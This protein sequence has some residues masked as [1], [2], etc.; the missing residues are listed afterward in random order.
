MSE[1]GAAE[2]AALAPPLCHG[3]P[4]R[5]AGRRRFVVLDSAFGLGHSFL[6]LWDAWRNDPDRCDSLHVVAV[7]APAPTRSDLMQAHAASTLPLLVATLLESWPPLTPNLHVLDFEHGRV[8]LLLAVGPAATSMRMLRLQADAICLDATHGVWT[9]QRLKAVARLA[10]VGATLTVR[11]AGFEELASLPSA[12]FELGPGP[13]DRD[14]TVA[15]PCLA[16]YVAPCLAPCLAHYAPRHVSR[17]LPVL[18]RK[19][20]N[21]VVV[22]AGLAGAAVAQALARQGLSVTVLERQMAPA[23]G[24]SGN[25]AGLFHGTVNAADGHYARL[26][27]A[28]A[29]AASREYRAAMAGSG[30]HD[31]GAK[32]VMGQVNGLLRLATHEGGVAGLQAL[33]QQL[34]L[35]ADYVEVLD[36]AAAS[37]R[38]GVPLQEACWYYPGGGWLAPASWVQH[39]LRTPGITVRFDCEVAALRHDGDVWWLLNAAGAAVGH[40]AVVVLA[41]AEDAAKLLSPLGLGPWPLRVTRGQVTLWQADSPLHLPVA[42]DGYALPLPDGLLC[43]ATRQD[44]DTD[45]RVRM[46][47]H[48]HN[49]ARL[50]HLT[51]LLPPAD[52]AQWQ[53]RAGLR[54]H[55][56]DNLPIAGAVPARCFAPGQR[57]DQVRL[58][59][60]EPGLFA[61][62]ALGARGLT[63]APLLGRLIAAQATGAPWP[64]EQDLADAVDPAR[65][66]VRAARASTQA[67]GPVHRQTAGAVGD[68][69]GNEA[70]NE[71]GDREDKEAGARKSSPVSHLA[72]DAAKVQG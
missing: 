61:L 1:P 54:L 65:W 41:N 40:S 39:A 55:S 47:D 57:L 16:P 58:L 17:S 2:S 35:P 63:L 22:G 36:A 9:R 21:A 19:S 52:T 48:Q 18:A 32:G 30:G 34:R 71:A 70:G 15:A 11:N 49:V 3:L 10:A 46:E 12:G 51:G 60:R 59:P 56:A 7:A 45:L 28:A 42:G 68:Q 8:Q 69:A 13:G 67:D 14:G 44:G 5:W 25:P 20:R 43:G 26:F 38:A 31:R 23:Q 29:L 4:A 6:G 64:L 62:T 27:R 53:G 72:D 24:T 37:Q 50:Q 33:L 66:I